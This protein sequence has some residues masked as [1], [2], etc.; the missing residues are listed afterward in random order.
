MPETSCPLASDRTQR[1]RRETYRRRRI[2]GAA[3]LGSQRAVGHAAITCGPRGC[4]VH[5][6][7]FRL[8]RQTQPPTVGVNTS[9]DTASGVGSIHGSRP[10]WLKCHRGNSLPYEAAS[11]WLLSGTRKLKLAAL[12]TEARAYFVP[13]AQPQTPG[14]SR[15]QRK[16][17]HCKHALG[18]GC[19]GPD[20]FSSVFTNQ[21]SVRREICYSS[22]GDEYENYTL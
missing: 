19:R 3:A 1:Q 16:P 15:S 18:E 17:T 8:C 2:P 10:R 9:S 14:L 20:R 7:G 5:C 11:D 6:V 22:K 12:R 21:K 4:I 13:E